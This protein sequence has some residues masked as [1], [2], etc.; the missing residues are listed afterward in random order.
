MSKVNIDW[1]SLGFS[2]QPISQRYV[3]NYNDGKW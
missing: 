2:Y 1:N 3:A